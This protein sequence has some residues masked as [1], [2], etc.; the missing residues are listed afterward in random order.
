[1]PK[2][3]LRDLVVLLPG[4]TGSVLQKDG[5]DVWG[6]SGQAVWGAVQRRGAALDG[7]LLHDDDPEA[8][9]L[10]DGVRADRLMP[11]VH[12]VPGLVKI[13]GYSTIPKLLSD[14]FQLVRG[15]PSDDAPANFVEFPYDWRRDNRATARALKRLVDRRLPQWREYS[16]ARD[17]RVVLVAH[18]MG[19]LA[20]RYYLEVLEGWEHARAL[21]TF[22]TPYRGSLKALDYLANGYRKLFVDASEVMRSFTAMHQLLPVY[23]AV[24]SDGGWSR[25]AECAEI[26]NVDRERAADALAF[27]REI[28]AAADEHLRDVDYLRSRYVTIP[29]VGI[30]Q[31]TLQSATLADGRLNVSSDLPGGVDGWLDAGDGTVPRV[32]AIPIEQSDDHRGGFVPELHSSLQR[33]P[34]VLADLRG[35][36]QQLQARRVA[37]VRGPEEEAAALASSALSVDVADLYLAGEPFRLRAWLRATPETVEELGAPEALIRPAAD[38]AAPP[39]RRVLVPDANGWTLADDHPLAPG[40]YRL[41]VRTTRGGPLAPSPVHDVFAVGG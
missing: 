35:R 9:D 39:V 23:A 27:H 26:P 30:D 29:V 37:A 21:I 41:E 12:L 7:L 1:M 11:D 14:T 31:P 4:I 10:G 33:H 20:A 6:V 2:Q 40:V 22:G 38:T 19:G 13:D 36:L 24:A 25:V 5:K 17:A 18:S 15:T 28:E 8:A 34:G 32:S 3:L 16:G